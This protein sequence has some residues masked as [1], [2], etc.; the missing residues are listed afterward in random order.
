[1]GKSD[2]DGEAAG[3]RRESRAADIAPPQRVRLQV[4]AGAQG[5]VVDDPHLAGLP[6]PVPHLGLQVVVQGEVERA[7][8]IQLRRR[9]EPRRERVVDLED[10]PVKADHRITLAEH[11]IVAEAHLRRDH[12]ADGPQPSVPPVLEGAVEFGVGT[13]AHAPI[14]VGIE[15]RDGVGDHAVRHIGTDRLVE[16]AE[17]P[18]AVVR[19]IGREAHE[20]RL[21]LRGGRG[22]VLDPRL[23]P[24]YQPGQTLIEQGRVHP[25]DALLRLQGVG[26]T[27]PVVPAFLDGIRSQQLG[28]RQLESAHIDAHRRHDKVHP[29]RAAVLVVT[30]GG[31]DADRFA[32]QGS[33]VV[34]ARREGVGEVILLRT[35]ELGTEIPARPEVHIG[36]EAAIGARLR[37][38]AV[39]PTD[40]ELTA[41]RRPG[42]ACRSTGDDARPGDLQVAVETVAVTV[43]GRTGEAPGSAAVKVALDTGIPVITERLIPTEVL[44]EVAQI[45]AISEARKDESTAA[46]LLLGKPEEGQ[47]QRQRNLAD[48]DK[49]RTADHLLIG[50]EKA[51]RQV[52]MEMGTFRIAGGELATAQE[53]PAIGKTLRPIRMESQLP[54]LRDS[55][56]AQSLAA[57]QVV[58]QDILG[59]GLPILREDRAAH[60]GTGAVRN[61]LRLDLAFRGEVIDPRRLEHDARRLDLGL[62]AQGHPLLPDLEH[63]AVHRLVGDGV[64]YVRHE[65]IGRRGPGHHRKCGGRVPRRAFRTDGI[66]T[67]AQRETGQGSSAFNTIRRQPPQGGQVGKVTRW[68][69][70]K[71]NRRQAGRVQPHP[72]LGAQGT[73]GLRQGQGQAVRFGLVQRRA[74]GFG[75]IQGAP[76]AGDDHL[77]ERPVAKAAIQVTAGDLVVEPFLRRAGHEG[78]PPHLK[79]LGTALRQEQPDGI[80]GQLVRATPEDGL[81][82]KVHAVIGLRPQQPLRRPRHI[83]RMQRRSARCLQ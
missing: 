24:L 40:E 68:R 75:E 19:D 29:A 36:I 51:T 76:I 17:V 48:L 8:R 26:H 27:D 58:A 66:R 59:E 22:G 55:V 53:D 41:P 65:R 79:A 73:V 82:F 10:A 6:F 9:V 54:L 49:H 52:K 70:K 39:A 31:G 43:L 15:A 60:G 14:P 67:A 42:I 78:M 33:I 38:L 71:G 30:G 45:A 80:P 3:N 2:V 44:D 1:M 46:L 37:V 20:P 5:Q 7:L 69:L 56:A 25:R 61:A 21:D 50:H 81:P 32:G 18:I 63:D 57:V 11:R 35:V 13:D 28:N 64:R 12:V 74:V 4:V 77:I 72:D 16:R 47:T 83:V 34:D 62:A 23:G